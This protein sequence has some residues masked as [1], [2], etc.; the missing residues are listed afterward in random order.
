MQNS[1]LQIVIQN[2]HLVAQTAVQNFPSS[3]VQ[4]V[5]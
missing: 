5:K 1:S 4:Q 3:F 2:Y